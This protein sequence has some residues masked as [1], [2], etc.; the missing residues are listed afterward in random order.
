MAQFNVTLA[1]KIVWNKTMSRIVVSTGLAYQR[2]PPFQIER[3]HG[4]NQGQ[5]IKIERSG[6]QL[7]LNLSDELLD[8]DKPIGHG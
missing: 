5:H 3:Y 7:L 6:K 8:L 4:R 2:L 1:Q